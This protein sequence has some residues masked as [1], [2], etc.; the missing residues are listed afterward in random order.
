MSNISTSGSLLPAPLPV[1]TPAGNLDLNW[2]KTYFRPHFEKWIFGPIDRLVVSD[3]A[4]IGFIFMSCTI[5]YVAGFMCGGQT[6][7]TDYI[8][9]IKNYFP[10]GR[11]DARGIYDSLR[12]GLV[13]MF[14]IKGRKYCLTHNYPAGHLKSTWDGQ[15]V[16]EAGS[17]RDDLRDA[18]HRYFDMVEVDPVFSQKFVDRY[19]DFGFLDLNRIAIRW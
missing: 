4:L 7:R 11:Y 15:I 19:N 3:D 9:F 6:H 18:V 5:D 2:F 12:C 1:L 17:F 8:D 14:T 13:H 16:L 10:H